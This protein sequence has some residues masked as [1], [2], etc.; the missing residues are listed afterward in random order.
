MQLLGALP[1]PLPLPDSAVLFL[2]LL[3]LLALHALQ[4]RV[5]S[6]RLAPAT[7]HLL[8]PSTRFDWDQRA[9]NLAV[10]LLQAFFNCTILFLNAATAADPLYAYPPYAHAGFLA[11][12]AFYLY[13]ALLFFLHPSPP[14]RRFWLAHHF[15]AAG[16]LLWLTSRQQ[17]SAL[18]AATFLVSAAGH[19]PNEARWFLRAAP[20]ARA[21]ARANAV[22]VAGTF[23]LLATCIVPPPYLVLLAARTRGATWREMMFSHMLVQCQI[24]YWLVW[25]PH[26]AIVVV[27]V[28]RTVRH[29]NRE[30][31]F[32]LKEG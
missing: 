3:S 1:S 12:A 27:Q 10:Q 5:L 8:R 6:P 13:D 18:P 31:S 28:Q 17:T 2:S 32:A 11:V 14:H 29:W 24:V 4:R 16:A 22:G 15:L 19:V 9:L 25:L 21:R 26:C 30:P 20:G 7:Y 23:V